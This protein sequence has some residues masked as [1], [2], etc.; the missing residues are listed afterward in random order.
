MKIV[1]I[2]PDFGLAGAEIMCENLTRELIKLGYDV[3]VVSM[4]SIRTSITER[5]ENDGVD[6]RYLG[7]KRG[8]DIAMI[9]K[10][11][12]ILKQV[13]A[14]AI[15]TH[16]YC[17]Q[18]AIPAAIMAGVKIRVHTLHSIASEENRKSAR[19]L[20]AFFFKHCNLVPV[21]LS[22]LVQDSVTTEYCIAKEKIPVV[23]NGVDLSKCIS[24][25]SY[26]TKDRFVILHIGRFAEPKNHIGLLEAF[27]IFHANH[28]DS[29]IW[30]IGD[31]EKRGEVENYVKNHNLEKAVKFYGLQ[32]NVYGYL[33]NADVFILPSIYEGMPMTL[34]EAMGTGLPIVA[35]KVGGIPDMLEDSCA[36]LTDVNSIQ[37]ANALERYYADEM[38]RRNHGQAALRRSICFSA[39][40]M[41]R[42]Y[43]Q[44]YEASTRKKK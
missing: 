7:K 14:D 10:P 42:R 11:K 36:I 30:L 13:K 16:R 5:L 21:A 27:N 32:S 9:F 35:T 3:T 1:Q 12:K 39:E 23:Y 4:Y 25:K 22:E 26:A 8:L 6:V 19:K 17:A 2:M 31:G 28:A 38:L 24:K 43:C 33:H 44:I 15:H 18:Y 37:I 34:I 41:A 29:E 40:E 20:N